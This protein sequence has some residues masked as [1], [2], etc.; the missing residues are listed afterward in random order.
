MSILLD[1]IV[2]GSLSDAAVAMK[3]MSATEAKNHWGELVRAV[4]EGG[5]PVVIENRREPVLVAISPAD[6]EEFQTYKRELD[7]QRFREQLRKIQDVQSKLT[8][9]LTEEEAEAL[10]QRALAEDREERLQRMRPTS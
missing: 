2:F 5:E 10:V 6:F 7:L 1:I 4:T 8:A 9:D 3:R